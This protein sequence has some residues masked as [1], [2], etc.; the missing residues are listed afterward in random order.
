M[1]PDQRPEAVD[2]GL[3]SGLSVNGFSQEVGMAV[4]PGV[5]RDHDRVDKAQAHLGVALRVDEGLIQRAPEGR[6][7]DGFDLASV[8]CQV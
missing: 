6:L 4:V 3:V 7:A 5:L 2:T 8:T 1:T